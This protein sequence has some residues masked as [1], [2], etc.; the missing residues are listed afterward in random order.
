M[1]YKEDEICEPWATALTQDG[2]IAVTSCRNKF[3]QVMNATGDML[4]VFGE[5]VFERPA[6]IAIDKKGCYIVTDTITNR[7]SFHSQKGEF[8]NYLG[9]THNTLETF[10]SL[11]YVCCYENG[12]IIVSES[13]GHCFKIFNA[14][15][16]LFKTVRSFGK[17]KNQFKYPHGICTSPQGDIFVADHYNNRVSMFDAEGEFINHLMT[18]SKGLKHPHRIALSPEL[19][20]YVTHGQKF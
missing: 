4:V 6:G 8:L 7:V 17:G 11:R 3:V 10:N 18:S 9:N 5:G 15:G 13:G 12:D 1:M 20:L 14:S 19:N 16:K 2:H